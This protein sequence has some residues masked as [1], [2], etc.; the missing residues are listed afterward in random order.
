MTIPENKAAIG[1]KPNTSNALQKHGANY[2]FLVG[3]DAYQ[4]HQ[5]LMNAVSDARSV[6]KV[7]TEQYG[8]DADNVV[9]LYDEKATSDAI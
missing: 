9:E 8:F 7:L 4:H 3:I 6:K 5:K 2:L 1:R